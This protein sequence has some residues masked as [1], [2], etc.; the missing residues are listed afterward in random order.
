MKSE[1]KR[2]HHEG[3]SAIWHN[4]FGQTPPLGH[5]LRHDFHSAWTRFHSLPESK[6]YADT[7][8]ERQT[9]LLRANTL[10]ME[11]FGSNAKLWLVTGYTKD[12]LENSNDK[13]NLLTRFEMKEV[14]SWVDEKEEPEDQIPLIFFAARVEWKPEAFDWLFSMIAEDEERAVFFDPSADLAL[15]PY[16]GGFDLIALNEERPVHLEDKYAAWI[17][18]RLDLL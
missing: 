11:C 6:R 10:A 14:F 16:D 13:I 2:E 5:E 3:F 15:A 9:I 12:Y 4:T 1:N 7:P 18:K 17:S 8:D